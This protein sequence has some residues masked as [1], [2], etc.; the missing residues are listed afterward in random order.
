MQLAVNNDPLFL[1][2]LCLM[3]YAFFSGL[4]FSISFRQI[5]VLHKAKV[6]QRS[7]YKKRAIQALG[8]TLILNLVFFLLSI[9]DIFYF[10]TMY[11]L[12]SQELRFLA[13]YV[14]IFLGISL[15]FTFLWLNNL[16]S[17]KTNFIASISAFIAVV[18]HLKNFFLLIAFAYLFFY[19]TAPTEAVLFITPNAESAFMPLIAIINK[20][21]SIMQ[22]ISLDVPF[23]L[24]FALF[25]LLASTTLAYAW[26]LQSTLHSRNKDDFGRD[27]YM[28]ALKDLAKAGA[29]S[30]LLLTLFMLT[31]TALAYLG[32]QVMNMSFS[33]N[34]FILILMPLA[35]VNFFVIAFAQNPIRHKISISILTFMVLI[36]ITF[37]ILFTLA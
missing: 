16:Q 22:P 19:N 21:L 32:S 6:T 36:P 2:A 26:Q 33:Q 9:A 14:P 20:A 17:E 35:C 18:A 30:S 29:F 27:Y 3:M 24:L 23:F 25:M 34:N 28:L 37:F 10:Q 4:M 13:F 7:M 31:Y 1:L 11:G 15:V 12:L 8:S 5:F